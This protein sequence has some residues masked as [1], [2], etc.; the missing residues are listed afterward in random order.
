[1]G[2]IQ[3]LGKYTKSIHLAQGR[4]LGQKGL[5]RLYTYGLNSRFLGVGETVFLVNGST[6]GHKVKLM[7]V[8]EWM[9]LKA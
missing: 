1:M 5:Y 2:D 3:D 8:V 6:N 9:L 4:K 7:H